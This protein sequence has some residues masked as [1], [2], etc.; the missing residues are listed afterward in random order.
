VSLS[1]QR[2]AV[3]RWTV[4]GD[5]HGPVADRLRD[6]RRSPVLDVGCGDGA[7]AE[8]GVAGWIGVDLD[9][10][11]RPTLV[12]DA[13]A[14]PVRDGT[15]GAVT[16]LWCL[17]L[18]DEPERA[19]AEARRVLAPGGLFAACT[20][21]RDDAPELHEWF[22]PPEPSTFDAEEAPEV[23]ASVFGDVEVERWDAPLVHLPD[24]DAVVDYLTGR[25]ATAETAATVAAE[26]DLPLSIT[27]RGVLVWAHR[28]TEGDSGR[29]PTAIAFASEG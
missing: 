22:D 5:V 27:K 11:H 26:A 12:A 14:L 23:V 20:T 17:Y 29:F 8:Q 28:E 3:L 19:I 21:A 13:A 2:A 24:A 7:L 9:A 10:G 1:A 18:L 4:G 25:G 16:A 6:E 15:V